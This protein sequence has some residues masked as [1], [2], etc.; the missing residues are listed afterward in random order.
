MIIKLLTVLLLASCGNNNPNCPS[1]PNEPTPSP[2]PTPVP[3]EPTP[4]PVPP[5]P[6]TPP[7]PPPPP[8]PTDKKVDCYLKWELE[9]E[10]ANRHFVIFYN[11]VHKANK[12][13]YA[14]L[15]TEYHA[16]DEIVQGSEAS[17][18]YG[19][20]EPNS[21]EVSTYVWQASLKGMT[22][23]IRSNPLNEVKEVLCK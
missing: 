13:V 4:T 10:P 8:E 2:E 11:V 1:C 16:G 21:A 22:A 9:G 19:A 17:K 20:D 7:V 5:Q 14:A 3:P 12:E 6:P 15:R 18:T 23:K